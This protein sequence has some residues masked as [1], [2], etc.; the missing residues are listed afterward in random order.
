[1][2][3]AIKNITAHL[4]DARPCSLCKKRFGAIDAMKPRAW[5]FL[6]PPVLDASVNLLLGRAE[7]AGSDGINRYGAA[8]KK[9]RKTQEES[10]RETSKKER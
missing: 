8:G 6:C 1:M 7:P 4:L 2:P 9:N 10:G 3:V 5:W